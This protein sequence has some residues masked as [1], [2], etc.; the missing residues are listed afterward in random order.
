MLLLL[1]LVHAVYTAAALFPR[2][3]QEEMSFFLATV[4]L[5]RLCDDARKEAELEFKCVFELVLPLCV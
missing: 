2:D 4:S 1:S 5:A 3:A